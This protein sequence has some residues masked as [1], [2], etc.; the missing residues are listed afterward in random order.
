[1]YDLKLCIFCGGTDSEVV[2][3]VSDRKKYF[4]VQCNHCAARGSSYGAIVCIITGHFD[5]SDEEL[6]EQAIL[7][8]NNAGHPTVWQRWVA[9]PLNQ[10]R[11]EFGSWIDYQL[12]K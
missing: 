3:D 8:W 11:Y 4:F 7:A 9:R 6:I 12:T 1:M 5:E 2:A 10:L